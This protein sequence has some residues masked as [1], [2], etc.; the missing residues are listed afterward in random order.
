MSLSIKKTNHPFGLSRIQTRKEKKKDQHQHHRPIHPNH[1]TKT[2][3]L[4]SQTAKSIHF[5]HQQQNPI[6]CANICMH[7]PN[8]IHRTSSTLPSS[9]QTTQSTNQRKQASQQSTIPAPA[10]P[11]LMERKIHLSQVSK[12][13]DQVRKERRN[14]PPPYSKLKCPLVSSVQ[15]FGKG[16]GSKNEA[17]WREKLFVCEE[18]NEGM[19]GWMDSTEMCVVLEIDGW[20]LLMELY[21]SS[22]SSSPLAM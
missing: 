15:A 7:Q 8:L 21:D 5:L 9:N 18:I 14:T 11:A 16:R 13:Q 12:H 10:Q 19:N 22:L 2:P 3:N 20:D 17:R 4:T 6:K 1:Q